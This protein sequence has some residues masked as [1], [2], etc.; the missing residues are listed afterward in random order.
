MIPI[1]LEDVESSR[2]PQV[3]VI[4][5][6]EGLSQCRVADLR[7][8][9]F[10]GLCGAAGLLEIS[11]ACRDTDMTVGLI[12]D[13]GVSNQTPAVIKINRDMTVNGKT[14]AEPRTF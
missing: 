1:V 12:I 11:V 4:L 7:C 10:A 3:G 2:L 5:K 13:A 14:E 8:G 9:F 6:K